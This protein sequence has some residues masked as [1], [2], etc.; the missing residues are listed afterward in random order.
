MMKANVKN[1]K[2]KHLFRIKLFFLFLLCIMLSCRL[3]AHAKE[4]TGSAIPDNHHE[5]EQRVFRDKIPDNQK[6]SAP[7][8]IDGE[9][10][11]I[12]KGTGDASVQVNINIP[13]SYR[14][15]NTIIIQISNDTTK[16]VYELGLY[17]ENSYTERMNIP[18]GDYTVI[19]AMVVNDY[20][21][22]YAIPT[23]Q[24]F[25]VKKGDSST[26]G[27][28]LDVQPRQLEESKN[29]LL[30]ET[31]I[32]PET[33]G[34][35]RKQTSKKSDSFVITISFF[36]AALLLFSAITYFHRKKKKGMGRKTNIF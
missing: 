25:T 10:E 32:T 17:Y 8:S 13:V 33:P 19:T 14:L 18:E 20:S 6:I 24:K 1:K 22:Y 21:G 35:Q 28:T 16:D 29:G 2:P 11:V 34:Q 23:G 26:H 31:T 4:L 9:M 3:T 15:T 12:T 36:F 30:S 7:S 5:W 27:I